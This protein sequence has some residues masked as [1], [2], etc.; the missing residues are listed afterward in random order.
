M[1]PW[2][3]KFDSEI[4]KPKSNK[5]K[6]NF[7]VSSMQKKIHKIKKKKYDN[8]KKIPMLEQIYELP[9]S[10]RIIEGF[11]YKE[12]GHLAKTEMKNIF[13]SKDSVKKSEK[14]SESF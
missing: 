12:D 13:P 4:E 3:K 8:P 7:D 14:D 11:H 1:S 5:I 2:K 10:G 6:E 9:Q